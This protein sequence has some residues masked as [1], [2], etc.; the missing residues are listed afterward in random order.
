[1]FKYIFITFYICSVYSNPNNKHIDIYDGTI[2]L[3]NNNIMNIVENPDNTYIKSNSNSICEF[4]YYNKDPNRY[5]ITISKNNNIVCY[6]LYNNTE[7]TD[8]IDHNCRTNKIIQKPT[9]KK[10]S[11]LSWIVY[12]TILDMLLSKK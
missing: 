7:I 1:M 2:Y 12:F 4:K 8:V 3:T 10:R 11:A 9:K 5:K 6:K